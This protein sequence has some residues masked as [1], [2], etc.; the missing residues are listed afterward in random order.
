MAS[1]AADSATF[2]DLALALT[3][4]E[5]RSLLKRISSSL[6][7]RGTV[8][9]APVSSEGAAASRADAITR[10]IEAMGFWRRVRLFLRRLFSARN[11][12][13]TYV[14]FRLAEIRRRA[15]SVLPG[16][17]PLEHHTIEPVVAV[18][19]WELYRHAYA[20]IPFFLDLWRGGSLL[21]ETVGFLL[22]QRIPAAKEHLGDFASLGELQEAFLEHELKSSVR[23][24]VVDRLDAYV[25]GVP[26]E[27]FRKLSEGLAPL[28]HLRQIALLDYNAF[29]ATFGFDPGI[30]PPEEVP[31]FK[32]TPAS[33][34]LPMIEALYLGLHTAAKLSNDFYVHTE[35]L[36]RYLELKDR[37]DNRATDAS[38]A[39]DV[40]TGVDPTMAE[41]S[42]EEGY[43]AR[44]ERVEQLRAGMHDLHDACRSVSRRVPFADLIRYYSRDPWLR[45]KPY[46]PE[47]RLKE[48]YR[49]HL[50]IRVL[51]ELDA[52]FAEIRRGVVDRMVK[53]LFG[54]P[55]PPM[56][57]FRT[58]VQLVSDKVGGPDFRRIRSLTL[59]NAFLRFLYR[60][61]MQEMFRTLGRIL[62]VRQ[63]DSSS[64]LVVHVAGMDE[65]Y[66]DIEDFDE[67][68]SPDTDDGKSYYRVR[69]GVEKDASLNRSYR[70]MVSQR[71][72]EATLLV[73]RTAEHARG[74]LKVCEAIRAGLTDQTRERYAAV[75]RRVNEVD[76]LDVLI[77]QQAA[78][79][80]QFDRLIKQVRAMEEGY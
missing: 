56:A 38:G 71:D 21:Q 70:N 6:S 49:S 36:D 52:R 77:E 33:A 31:P 23:K 47:I 27:L 60:G 66:A 64:D 51:S 61:R 45:V 22:A 75:D 12:E 43:R 41:R 15:R 3:E 11:D 34:G 40:A 62:P 65:T 32:E 5:R 78:K 30:A 2:R 68:F 28:Y 29:F 44:K 35:V 48:F 74:L 26:K 57:F 67:S 16:L 72:R 24:L 1:G 58:G 25:D 39:V 37:E 54:A 79:L 46:A 9:E 42:E 4:E 63:R 7:L 53:R 50:M 19:V 76:G 14:E 10:E 18:E 69:Y 59:A 73:D 20:V 8:S 80:E 13:Q 55:P 17:A